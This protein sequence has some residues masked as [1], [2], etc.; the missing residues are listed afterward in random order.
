MA[1]LLQT[2]SFKSDSLAPAHEAVAVTPSD[3]TVVLFRGLYIGSGGDLAVRMAKDTSAVTFVA[4]LG[5]TFL[6]LAVV[7]VMST[8]TTASNIVGLK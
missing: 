1:L 7:R 5:G 3:S 6:P 4:V 8:N 2:A